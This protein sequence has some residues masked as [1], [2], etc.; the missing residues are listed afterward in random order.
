MEQ[1]R[2]ELAARSSSRR[3]DYTLTDQRIVRT[4]PEPVP[5]QVK[6]DFFFILFNSKKNLCIF[7]NKFERCLKVGYRTRRQ[8]QQHLPQTI[9][10]I[11]VDMLR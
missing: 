1:K 6:V 4:E 8:V 3:T 5:S 10:T 2:K 9:N 7:R 11:G